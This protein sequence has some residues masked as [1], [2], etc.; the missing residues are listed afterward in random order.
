MSET[1]DIN[2]YIR[3]LVIPVPYRDPLRFAEV[4]CH[5]IAPNEAFFDTQR[6][7]RQYLVKAYF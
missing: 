5:A 2:D 4:M 3:N 7:I 6:M 1:I